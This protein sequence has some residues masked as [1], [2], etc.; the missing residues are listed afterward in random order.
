MPDVNSVIK[1][2]RKKKKKKQNIFAA[3]FQ[4][5][6][7]WKGDTAGEIIRKIVFLASLVLLTVTGYIILDTYV[8][9]P[10]RESAKYRE[11]ILTLYNQEPTAAELEQL[12][13]KTINTE[14]APLYAANNDFVGYLNILNT[15]VNYPVVQ[16]V[17]ND[18]YLHRDFYYDYSDSGT[19]FADYENVFSPTEPMSANTIIYGHN[20]RIDSFFTEVARY[21]SYRYDLDYFKDRAVIEFNTLYDNAKYKIFSVMLV[22]TTDDY[23]EVFPY[24]TKINFRSR[25]E[26]NSFVAECF[27]RS[28]YYTGVDVKYGDELLTLSTCEFESGLSDMRVVVVARKVRDGESADFTEE[29]KEAFYENPV[30]KLNEL[31]QDWYGEFEYRYWDPAWLEGYVPDDSFVDINEE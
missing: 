24:Q 12:P 17:D 14:Y 10:A 8:F 25:D 27:D 6:I 2:N 4:G 3:I 16:G 21:Y 15:S 1:T 26:F 11:E 28:K 7:P 30:P 19:V 23:G 31:M 5:L 29:E 22:N 9:A 13:E 20:M 18:E